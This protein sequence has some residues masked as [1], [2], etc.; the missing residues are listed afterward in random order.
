MFFE[1]RIEAQRPLV[2]NM[3]IMRSNDDCEKGNLP[4]LQ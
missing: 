3:R 4:K 1:V 2:H